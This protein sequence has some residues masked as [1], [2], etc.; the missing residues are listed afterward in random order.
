MCVT[1]L[2]VISA[3]S[4]PKPTG[5]AAPADALGE[6]KRMHTSDAESKESCECPTCGRDDFESWH[7][8]RIH[9]G[10]EHGVKLDTVETECAWCGTTLKRPRG[11]IESSE[12]QFCDES[13]Q[14]QWRSVNRSGKNSPNWRRKTVECEVC[15]DEFD[16]PPSR[17]EQNGD[18]FCS[19][20]CYGVWYSKNRTG[21]KHPRW[22][23]GYS[24][25]YGP[26]WQSQRRKALDRDGHQCVI[27]GDGSKVDVHHIRPFRQF[28]VKNH[29]DA[30]D[31]ENLVC[32]CP[33]HHGRWEGIPLRPEVVDL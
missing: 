30:N 12:N 3:D 29:T 9:H 21:E 22:Q 19:H 13:C 16:V 18:R 2:P 4:A 20:A 23:G 14:G 17:A 6:S 7:G 32:L 1:D 15:G 5:V 26:S 24:D 33:V 27:C 28:G 31:L 10:Y 8:V 11:R 25:Y